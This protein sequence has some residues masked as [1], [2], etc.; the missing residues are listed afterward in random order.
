MAGILKAL[1]NGAYQPAPAAG[2]TIN[3]AVLKGENIIDISAVV[4]RVT[5]NG[6]RINSRHQQ[7]NP[8]L[9]ATICSAGKAGGSNM[10]DIKTVFVSSLTGA[11]EGEWFVALDVSKGIKGKSATKKRSSVVGNTDT[12]VFSRTHSTHGAVRLAS[13]YNGKRVAEVPSEPVVHA[14]NAAAYPVPKDVSINGSRSNAF[15]NLSSGVEDTNAN[16]SC[17][18][19]KEL[20]VGNENLISC[21]AG[22]YMIRMD[23]VLKL[24]LENK[25][26]CVL[27]LKLI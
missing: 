24:I 6:H 15:R 10:D 9:I 23:K 18:Q 26:I 2:E 21:Q 16:Y 20:Q 1:T 3:P 22:N 27:S 12:A 8:N 4:G 17:T 11:S 19:I 5:K 13:V 7:S 25:R 14:I